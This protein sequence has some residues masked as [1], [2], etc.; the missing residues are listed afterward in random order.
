MKP[1]LLFNISESN[2]EWNKSVLAMAKEERE[3]RFNGPKPSAQPAEKV[4]I[5]AGQTIA[6]SSPAKAG[7][8]S[9]KPST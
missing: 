6:A 7:A 5:E 4:V 3:R 8:P 2:N 9:D 1:M